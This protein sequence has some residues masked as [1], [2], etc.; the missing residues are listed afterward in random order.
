MGKGTLNEAEQLI[1]S[2][3]WRECRLKLEACKVAS[4]ICPI[5]CCFILPA[6]ILPAPRD[7]VPLYQRFMS[8]F[9]WHGSHCPLS[10]ALHTSHSSLFPF[11]FLAIF[12]PI[13]TQ[14]KVCLLSE[15][16]LWCFSKKES[17][18]ICLLVFAVYR[19]STGSLAVVTA[20]MCYMPIS[21]TTWKDRNSVWFIFSS[22]HPPQ[23]LHLLSAKYILNEC[24]MPVL[25]LSGWRL[26]CS[27]FLFLSS[28][29]LSL[30]FCLKCPIS[31]STVWAE[32][33]RAGAMSYCAGD[34]LITWWG[35]CTNLWHNRSL[36]IKYFFCPKKGKILPLV[37]S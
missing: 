14:I 35:P 5:M 31:F 26:L 23:G 19:N 27:V 24:L 11:S 7:L 22:Q 36:L 12:I 1:S 16:F 34:L 18:P 4:S 30:A 20:L 13:S 2:K 21:S 17:L 28:P 3:T 32:I 37:Q 15:D 25:E 9:E 10:C 6:L 33:E 29:L 8:Y